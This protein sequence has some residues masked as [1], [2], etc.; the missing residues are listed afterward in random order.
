MSVA[1]K[2]LLIMEVNQVLAYIHNNKTK[3]VDF[4]IQ[5]KKL[6]YNDKY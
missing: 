3:Y 2:L 6:I 5:N 1:K 4:G